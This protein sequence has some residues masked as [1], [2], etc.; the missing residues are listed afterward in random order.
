MIVFIIFLVVKLWALGNRSIIM[1]KRPLASEKFAIG[2]WN[3]VYNYLTLLV[4]F[5]IGLF[6]A[7][8]TT[9]FEK[10]L[11]LPVPDVNTGVKKDNLY[12]M[13]V[14]SVFAHFTILINALLQIVVK[15]NPDWLETVLQNEKILKEQYED[16][17]K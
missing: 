13:Y 2:K 1:S 6:V 16:K 5:H 9:V 14:F 8:R 7:L 4:P 11:R 10:I 15:K 3:S 12:M 17:K